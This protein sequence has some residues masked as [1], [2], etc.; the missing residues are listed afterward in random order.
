MLLITNTLPCPNNCIIYAIKGG[1][2]I[3]NNI[4]PICLGNQQ[5]L[6]PQG[7][8]APVAVPGMLLRGGWTPSHLGDSPNYIPRQQR[9]SQPSIFAGEMHP[10]LAAIKAESLG[11][12]QPVLHV[13][14]NINRY[15]E[16]PYYM[17]TPSLVQMAH[18]NSNSSS[19]TNSP[20]TGRKLPRI[21]PPERRIL[22]RSPQSDLFPRFQQHRHQLDSGS[23]SQIPFPNELVQ[24]KFEPS[25]YFHILSIEMSNIN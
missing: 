8:G 17:K 25:K 11:H 22:R 5:F 10:H 1:V 14:Y 20:S 7:G 18:N 12:S 15:T 23:T 3:I 6:K 16:F 9:R 13:D 2:W 21:P 24:P 19:N 4:R